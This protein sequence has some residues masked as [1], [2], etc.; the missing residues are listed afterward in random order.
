MAPLYMLRFEPGKADDSI[1]VS[2]T[3][4]ETISFSMLRLEP[5]KVDYSVVSL[6]RA[7]RRGNGLL[8]MRMRHPSFCTREAAP[9][10]PRMPRLVVIGAAPLGAA[11]PDEAKLGRPACA[12]ATQ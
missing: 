3:R 4:G 12:A 9:V 10:G 2:L 5:G 6:T 8:G 11:P 7:A 1:V